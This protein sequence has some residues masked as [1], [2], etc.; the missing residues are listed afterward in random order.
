MSKVVNK[1]SFIALLSSSWKFCNT[2]PSSRLKFAVLYSV[3]VEIC[4]GSYRE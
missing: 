2:V 1:I 4:A 3:K